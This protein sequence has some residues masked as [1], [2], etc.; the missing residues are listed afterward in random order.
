MKSAKPKLDR[1]T[2]TYGLNFGGRVKVASIKNFQLVDPI[3]QNSLVLQFG[4]TSED[5]FAL[6]AFY[7]L[8]PIEA[9]SIA[10]TVFEAYEK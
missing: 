1:E 10:L 4:R 2:K 5:S 3:H 9:F 6:D 8:T 7:P